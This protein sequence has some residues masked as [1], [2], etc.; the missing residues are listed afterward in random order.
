MLTLALAP[1]DRFLAWDREEAQGRLL[2]ARPG[3]RAAEHGQD[4]ERERH[5]EAGALQIHSAYR[6][7]REYKSPVVDKLEGCSPHWLWPYL[8]NGRRYAM[9]G[10]MELGVASP[11]SPCRPRPG[12]DRTRGTR[13]DG[14]SSQTDR[15]PSSR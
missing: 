14:S 6:G 9:S 4:R 7:G 11:A 5:E 2:V 3:R 15:C 8:T 13:K 1:R 10:S 12:P